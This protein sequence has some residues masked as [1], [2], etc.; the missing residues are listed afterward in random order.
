MKS[1]AHL[2]GHPLH[3]ILIPY[4]FALLTSAT[5]FDVAARATGREDLSPTAHHISKAGLACALVAALPGIIDYFGTVP[6]R[7][8]A[9]KIATA[10][11]L[12]NV[13]ALT[14]FALAESS[15]DD[16]RRLSKQGLVLSLAGTAI[17]SYSGWLGGKLIYH[18]SIGVDEE[19]AG[20]VHVPA[21]S[22]Q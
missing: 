11:A 15:R 7:S 18:E 8:R 14:C 12:L 5:A 4:P 22:P 2:Q 16:G 9:K 3:P 1:T 19:R 21:L 6:R 17:L 20:I 10:H 13:S